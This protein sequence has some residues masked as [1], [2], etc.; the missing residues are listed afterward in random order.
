MKPLHV[1]TPPTEREPAPNT[2]IAGTDFTR[3]STF[4]VA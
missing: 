2:V 1:I 3:F 4:Y